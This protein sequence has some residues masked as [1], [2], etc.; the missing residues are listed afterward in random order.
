MASSTLSSLMNHIKYY[1]SICISTY[2]WKVKKKKEYNRDQ[3]SYIPDFDVINKVSLKQTPVEGNFR[4]NCS[5]TYT[6]VFGIPCVHSMVVSET[7]K[8][9]WKEITHHD[10]SVRW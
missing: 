4:L 2:D 6:E 8:H 3:R 7:F 5:C 10:I 9:K 1:D